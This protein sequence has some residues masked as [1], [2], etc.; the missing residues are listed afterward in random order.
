MVLEIFNDIRS[1]ICSLKGYFNFDATIK[2]SRMLK[3][4]DIQSCKKSHLGM[5]E[6]GCG[7]PPY[8]SM[9]GGAA[10]F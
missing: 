1:L 6:Q 2:I 4:T 5:S 10:E 8:E 7:T 3:V 9:K